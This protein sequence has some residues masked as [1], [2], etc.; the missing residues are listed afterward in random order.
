MD[1]WYKI[2]TPRREVRE[3]RSFS[4]DEFAI[5]LEQVVRGRGPEDYRDPRQFFS[6][7]CFTRR[8]DRAHG[9]SATAPVGPNARYPAGRHAGDPIRRGQDTYPDVA[10]PRCGHR[11]S[12]V[13]AAGHGRRTLC[14]RVGSN[15]G[16]SRRR[17]RRQRVG[18]GGRARDAMD[19]LGETARGGPGRERSR[20]DG[21]HDSARHR[22]HHPRVGGVKRTGAAPVRRGAQ[23]REQTPEHGGQLRC[24][25]PQPDGRRHGHYPRSGSDQPPAQPS[26]DDRVGSRV[27]RPDHQGRTARGA[28]SH[29]ERRVRDQRGGAPPTLRGPRE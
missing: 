25:P 26:G 24:L 10:L 4:P 28:R 29:R 8:P 20:P 6:R 12:G 5:A 23:L 9:D 22:S 2:V 27:A 1:P 16:G 3:G 14:R 11:A 21:T 18:P 17:L 7:T 13:R 15:P 19:R